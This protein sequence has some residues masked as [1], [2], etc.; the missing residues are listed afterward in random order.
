[1]R[2]IIEGFSKNQFVNDGSF[3]SSTFTPQ[4]IPR[5]QSHYSV[6]PSLGTSVSPMTDIATPRSANGIGLSRLRLFSSIILLRLS[7]RQ[8]ISFSVVPSLF[9]I[10]PRLA[11]L[12]KGEYC[13]E[14]EN[15]QEEPI[16]RSLIGDAT[17]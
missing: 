11:M 1:M 5:D 6:H 13:D 4:E 8:R 9:F 2:T 7:L 10:C 15:V 17:T 12:C 3:F 16:V 14:P